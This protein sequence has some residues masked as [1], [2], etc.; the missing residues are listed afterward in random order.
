[1]YHHFSQQYGVMV[2]FERPVYMN[3]LFQEFTQWK[4]FNE[5]YGSFAG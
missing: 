3:G 1:M 2:S 4:D 5:Q